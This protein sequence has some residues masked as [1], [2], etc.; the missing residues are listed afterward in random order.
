MD[1][2]TSRD[3]EHTGIP[4]QVS[5]WGDWKDVRYMQ[6]RK[7]SPFV[8]MLY[9]AALDQMQSMAEVCGDT[10]RRQQYAKLYSQTYESVNRGTDKG[11]MWNGSYYDQVWKDGSTRGL[12]CQDQMVGVL[13]DVIPRERAYSIVEALNKYALTPYGICNQYPYLPDVEYPEATYHNG[14]MWPWVSFMD[15]WARFRLGR[16]NEAIDLLQRVFRA[17]IEDSGDFVPNE[18]INTLTG[19]NLGFTV[20]GWNANLFGLMYFGLLH[21]DLDYKLPAVANSR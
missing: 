6:D 21:P 4:Q 13:Y 15:C 1:W 20:Q 17:D 3:M 5:F 7:Y 16:S 9:L 10:E 11:G 12:L 14:A 19:E 18:D 2:V 8:A